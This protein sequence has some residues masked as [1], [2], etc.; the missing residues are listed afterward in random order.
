MKQ[1]RYAGVLVR[2]GNKVL[3]CKR[4]N[5]GTLPGEWS[6]PG[7]SAEEGEN[8]VDGAM[9]EFHEETNNHIEFPLN[10]CGMIERYTR[11]GKRIKGLM[12][13]FC[14][15]SPEE[16]HPDLENAMDGDEHVDYGYFGLDNL[17]TPLGEK[18]KE[19][20]KVVLSNQK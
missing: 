5:K 1:K 13:V 8:P 18:L 19:I 2:V 12:Y 20:I 16:I 14:M 6:V 10:L 7:G 17:P 9:R 11:D 15:D 3:L 4:N